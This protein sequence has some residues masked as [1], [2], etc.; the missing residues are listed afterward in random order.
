MTGLTDINWKAQLKLEFCLEQNNFALFVR[1]Q[2]PETQNH[3]LF[4]VPVGLLPVYI[5]H[6][7]NEFL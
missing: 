4:Q 7:H 1:N 3:E 5:L 6:E 2:I